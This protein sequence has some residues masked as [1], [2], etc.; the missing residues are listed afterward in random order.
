H[1]SAL[2]WGRVSPPV[3]PALSGSRP[4]PERLRRPPP[5]EAQ[6]CDNGSSPPQKPQPTFGAFWYLGRRM[7]CEQAK[8][9][10]CHFFWT[11]SRLRTL[12]DGPPALT[13]KHWRYASG[14]SAEANMAVL[15]HGRHGYNGPAGHR[16]MRAQHGAHAPQQGRRTARGVIALY[17]GQENGP[18]RR[19]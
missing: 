10:S 17:C 12:R 18:C 8:V 9:T 5:V 3:R 2:P 7:R 6:V 15:L 16:P 14:T 19:N 11:T 1:R 4:P 13:K